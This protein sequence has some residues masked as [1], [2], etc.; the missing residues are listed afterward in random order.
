M[1]KHRIFSVFL[2]ALV[3][4]LGFF[5]Y[6]SEH[7]G[8]AFSGFPFRYGLDLNGGT[9]LTYNADVSKLQSGDVSGAMSTLRDVIERRVNA[10]GVSEASVRVE[11]AGIISGNSEHRLVVDLPGVTDTEKAIGIIGQ[12]PS[13]EFK[14]LPYTDQE[15]ADK[16]GTSTLADHPE[17]FQPTGLTGGLLQHAQITFSSGGGTQLANQPTVTLQFNDQGRQL[18]ADLTKNNVGKVLGIF[19][20]NE[21]ISSPVI[22]EPIP[23]GNAQISGNFTPDEAKTL[24]R[25][26]NY[27][28][29]PVPINLASTQVVGATLGTQAKD[30]GFKA[31]I[32]GFILVVIFLLVLYRVPGFLAAAALLLYVGISLTL[33]KLFGITLTAAGIAGFIISMG[34]AIDANVIIFERLKDELR[35]GKKLF[36]SIHEG[37]HRAWAPVRDASISS[38]ITAVILYWLGNAAVKGFA[39]T[40][41][42]GTLV[43]IFTA[44]TVTRTFLYAVV[45]EQTKETPLLRKLFGGRKADNQTT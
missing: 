41:G 27:G 15:L 9:E 5:L 17:L 42:I 1:I 8:N 3:I 34:I 36:Q 23:D 44:V 35:S 14:L 32:V 18:F 20:D 40:F 4:L 43:S 19:L 29:L 30:L 25:N 16:L 28:A 37:F 26:L 12:T 6:A 33:F 38:L 10:F 45:T 11:D 21:L 39:V 24:V 13:L 2:V 7:P 31:G 22:N